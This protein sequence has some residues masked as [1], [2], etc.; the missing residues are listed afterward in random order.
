MQE[1]ILIEIDLFDSTVD[2]S[3][4]LARASTLTER[5]RTRT[6]FEITGEGGKGGI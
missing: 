5:T 4:T 6:R 2:V 3:H 1:E